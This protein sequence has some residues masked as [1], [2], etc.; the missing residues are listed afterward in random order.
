V[1]PLRPAVCAAAGGRGAPCLTVKT[2]PLQARILVH[3]KVT[4]L[5]YYVAEADAAR[6]YDRV[7][8]AMHGSAP[9]N[10]P[11][12]QYSAADIAQL[13]SLDRASLQQALGVKP[14]QKSSR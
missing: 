5:G 6:A 14:M 8:L 1:I 10:F 9:T 2:A 3:G 7:S 11:A 13:H 12:S 4:H